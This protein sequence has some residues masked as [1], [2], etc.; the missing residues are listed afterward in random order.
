MLLNSLLFIVGLMA[1]DALALPVK[2]QQATKLG[3]V[4]LAVRFPLLDPCARR[5]A[6]I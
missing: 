3:G 1:V 2:R 6:D 5:I 4:N